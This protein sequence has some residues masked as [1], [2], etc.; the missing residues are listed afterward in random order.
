[1]KTNETEQRV[2]YADTDHG[3]VVYYSNYLKW[4]EI[5]RTEILRQLGLNYADF[6][7]KGLIAPVVEVKCSYRGPALYND[8]IIIRTKIENMGNSSIRFS[9]EIINR[10]N[11]KLLAEG[12]TVNVFVDRKT[13]KSARIPE[14]LRKAMQD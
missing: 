11:G 13:M 5:G 7:K 8:I 1:M 2:Y 6:E 3:G 9:Y 10:K 4:F 12:Y 14:E